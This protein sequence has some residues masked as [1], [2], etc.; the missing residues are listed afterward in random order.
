LWLLGAL[1]GA[2]LAYV[3]FF[4]RCCGPETIPVP[5]RSVRED[6]APAEEIHPGEREQLERVLREHG[7]TR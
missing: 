3:L 4:W 5:G 7:R 6:T 2:A 1:A